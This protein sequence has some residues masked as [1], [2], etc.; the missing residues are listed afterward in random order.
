MA[1]HVKRRLPGSTHLRL[2]IGGFAG[3][4]HGTA[5]TMLEGAARGT[6]VRRGGEIVELNRTPRATIDFGNGPT[7]T[8]GV[9]WGDVATAWFSTHIPN[10]D[11]FFEAAGMSTLLAAISGRFRR[12]LGNRWI[13][14]WAERQIEKRLPAGPS[15]KQRARARSVIVAEAWDEQGARAVSRLETIEAYTFAAQSAVEIARRAAHNEASPGFQ[16]PST[17]Y[18]PDFILTFNGTERTDL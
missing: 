15:R 13:R 16:T 6:L 10:I 5:R 17:A 8:I 14:K 3:I 9:S 12:F 4:T 2:S 7:P 11:V 1:S 18:G